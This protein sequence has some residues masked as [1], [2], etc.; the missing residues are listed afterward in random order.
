MCCAT[1]EQLPHRH[2]ST[3]SLG[4]E[5]QHGRPSVGLPRPG[6]DDHRAGGREHPD[7]TDARR[8]E[9]RLGVDNRRLGFT[10]L[11]H[12]LQPSGMIRPSHRLSTSPGKPT[13]PRTR[14][15]SQQ[16][17][18]AGKWPVYPKTATWARDARS[19]RAGLSWRIASLRNVHAGGQTSQREDRG[20]PAIA[21]RCKS[22]RSFQRISSLPC[23]HRKRYPSHSAGPQ[24]RSTTA[25]S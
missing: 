6:T 20:F 13:F 8:T 1:Q 11:S 10:I 9:Q 3:G 21:Q 22:R 17:R 2:F 23:R 25:L 16:V 15:R 18:S 7:S 19:F 14:P 24:R 12:I 4:A 5:Y